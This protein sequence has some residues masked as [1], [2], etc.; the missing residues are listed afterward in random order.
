MAT[1]DQRAGKNVKQSRNALNQTR[2][3]SEAEDAN[4]S[5]V[6]SE[7]AEES[8]KELYAQILMKS[9]LE[10]P[11]NVNRDGLR[12]STE[13]ANLNAETMKICQEI[14]ASVN[15]DVDITHRENA[16]QFAKIM[17]YG[18]QQAVSAEMLMMSKSMG[19]A[20]RAQLTLS[21][22]KTD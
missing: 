12:I 1:T 5:Q 6:I 10:L 13:D 14:N 21:Q 19:N 17:K 7:T 20:H 3:M 4:V 9:L 2:L 8:A 16:T 11:V 22:D 15:Q 18:L